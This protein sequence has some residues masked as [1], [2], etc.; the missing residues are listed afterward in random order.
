LLNNFNVQFFKLNGIIP[1]LIV[2]LGRK[3]VSIKVE[4]VNV[5]INYNL[6]LGWSWLYEMKEFISSLFRVMKFP[7]KGNIVT[8]HEIAYVM[9]NPSAKFG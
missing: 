2:D 4:V 7:H 5:L 9:P 1:T 6:L 8:I 3:I